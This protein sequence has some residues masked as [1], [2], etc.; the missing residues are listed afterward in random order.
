MIS[1]H[2][3]FKF[4]DRASAKTIVLVPGWATDHRVFAGFDCAYNYVLCTAVN[5]IDFADALVQYLDGQHIDTVSV[6][7]WSMGGYLAYDFTVAYPSRVSALRLAGIRESFEPAAL[8]GIKEKLRI[9]RAAFLYGFYRDCFSGADTQGYAIFRR[10]LMK[11]YVEEMTVAGLAAG[12]EYLAKVNMRGRL[13]RPDRGSGP[14][15]SRLQQ[16]S[17]TII[18]GS[19]DAI[20]P[21]AEARAVAQRNNAVFV[22]L[23]GVGHCPFMNNEFSIR[24]MS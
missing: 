23:K 9:N 11:A 18:H 8:A 17:F 16:V 13:L 1:P 14:T 6:F 20:A 7:G 2:S 15:A 3:S 21:V 19:D 24:L 10:Q 22:E 12:L 4:I 5:D